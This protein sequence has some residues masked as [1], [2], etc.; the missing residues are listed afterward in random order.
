MLLNEVFPWMQKDSALSTTLRKRTI[1][2]EKLVILRLLGDIISSAHKLVS[3]LSVLQN[4]EN[5]NCENNFV[6]FFSNYTLALLSKF[7]QRP[8]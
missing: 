5:N 8:V 6:L 2:T 7:S 3:C 4:L 1:L